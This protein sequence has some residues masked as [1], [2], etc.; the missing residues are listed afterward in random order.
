MMARLRGMRFTR[1]L[2]LLQIGLVTL[3]VGIGF[4]L[5]AWLLDQS[6]EHQYE[7]RALNVARTVAAEQQLGDLVRAGNQAAVQQI[8]LKASNA[9]GALFVV[10][11]DAHGIRLAH[12]SPDQIG[13]PV[14]TDPSEALSGREVVNIERGTLG[15][16]ARGKVP[17]RDSAGVIVGEVSVGFDAA[18]IRQALLDLLGATA[19]FAVG[20]LLLGVGGSTWLSRVLKR[21]TFGLEPAD[22]ADLVREREAVLHG[23][24]EGV[25][26]VDTDRRVTMCN[27]EAVRLLGRPVQPGVSLTE[28]DLPPRL[29][30]VLD[31][32]RADNILTV[33]GDRVLV[34]NHRPVHRDGRDLGSVLTLRD[35]TDLEQLTSELDAVRSMTGALRAQRHEFANRMHTVLGLLQADAQGDALEYLKAVTQFQDADSISESPAVRSATIRS[36]MAAKTA[37]A[38]E[39]GVTL[40]LSEAS[41]VQQK[42]V[43]PVEVVTVLGNLVDNALDA[44]HASTRRPG[45]VE[46][47]LLSEGTRL[48]ISVANTGDGVSPEQSEAIF[49]E[50]ISTRGTDR[51]LGL[52]IAR[53]TARGLGGDITLAN[54]G[55]DGT[56]TVFVAQL[57]DVLEKAP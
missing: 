35:R 2:L 13:K 39:L 25:L 18:E 28:L 37:R 10:V 4:G 46:V 27:D 6:L 24:G 51:G 50:G 48:V 33:A 15:L 43:A 54:P 56:E 20:A 22:L 12:P 3:V 30:S 7:Q 8:A 31:G 52:A 23:I 38:A 41:W 11:T 1:Q 53:Q 5:V 44:A 45:G 32:D 29:R 21:R 34:A 57:P 17:V 26:A 16:S 9:T 40:T 36:F 49:V 55:C 47:D 42:L 19:P 14:S